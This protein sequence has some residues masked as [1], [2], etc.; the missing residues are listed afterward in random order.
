MAHMQLQGIPD[1]PREGTHC[2]KGRASETQ[3]SP[4]TV[5]WA[6]YRGYIRIMEKKMETTVI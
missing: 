1:D 3:S 6:L 5:I 2:S 4:K